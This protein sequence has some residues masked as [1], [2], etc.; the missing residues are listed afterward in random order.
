MKISTQAEL[1]PVFRLLYNQA[2][3][4]LAVGKPIYLEVMAENEYKTKKQ[5]NLFHS[6][7]RCF[8][9]SGCSS[10]SNYDDMRHYYKRVAGLLKNKGKL[11]I[12]SSWSEVKKEDA[13]RVIDNLIRDMIYSGVNNKRFNDILKDIDH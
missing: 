5:N 1:K 8:W 4:L 11:I 9:D 12:E 10:F 3:A 13:R 2:E 6:L 7:L